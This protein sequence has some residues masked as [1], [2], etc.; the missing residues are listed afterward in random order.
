MRKSLPIDLCASALGVSF[1]G[2]SVDKMT[3]PTDEDAEAKAA[4]H[5]RM[6]ARGI[7]DLAVLR[8]LE[9][10]PRHKFVL[11][12]YRDLACRDLPIPIG[13]GQTLEAPSL[14]A[15]MIE[16]LRIGRDQRVLEIGSGSGYATAL[17]SQL[18]VEV[19]GVERFKSLAIGAQARL[20]ELTL[21]NAAV[22]WADGLSLP[23]TGQF[24]RILVHGLLVARPE[25]LLARLSDN[26]ALICALSTGDGQALVRL[27]KAPDDVQ[28]V[29]DGCR[30]QPIQQ[31]LA[32]AL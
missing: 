18:G 26:G 11:H 7:R 19:L 8:A 28:I 24:D 12:R 14:A 20:V 17:L 23:E 5:L 9:L 10:V 3:Q 29:L 4:F 2:A 6:R 31:G 30:L 21:S 13:C 25:H 16:A 15:I 22:V 1:I 27:S 32:A